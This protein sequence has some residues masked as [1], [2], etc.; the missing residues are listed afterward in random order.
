MIKI[1][2]KYLGSKQ[3]I[4]EFTVQDYSDAKEYFLQLIN[5]GLVFRPSENPSEK[6]FYGSVNYEDAAD[7]IFKG[8]Y[9][10]G[11]EFQISIGYEYSDKLAIYFGNLGINKILIKSLKPGIYIFQF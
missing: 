1:N 9:Q 7:T 2:A 6:V 11:L 4:L 10:L 3:H 5:D 8:G